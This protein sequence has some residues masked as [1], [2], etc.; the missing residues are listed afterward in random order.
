MHGLSLNL[1]DLG[2]EPASLESPTL[3][4]RFSTTST[5]WEAKGTE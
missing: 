2:L 4:G 1:P 5:T 3:A